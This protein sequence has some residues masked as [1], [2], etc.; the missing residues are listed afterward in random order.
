[1]SNSAKVEANAKYAKLYKIIENADGEN[2][3]NNKDDEK[4]DDSSVDSMDE[5]EDEED[6]FDELLWELLCVKCLKYDW[7]IYEC[8]QKHLELYYNIEKDDPYQEIMHDVE[9]EENNGS[10]FVDALDG[11]IRKHEH[12]IENAAFEYRNET[13][14][15]RHEP[16]NVWKYL[17]IPCKYRCNW[18]SI[19]ECKCE[20][21]SCSLL[22]RFRALALTLNAMKID[23]LIQDIV[24]SIEKRMDDISL[25][26]A[27]DRQLKQREDQIVSK[28]KIA[29]ERL[30]K[31]GYDEETL[32][33]MFEN[34]L[35]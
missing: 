15:W 17:A 23:D 22:R 35:Q 20:N 14:Y 31:K 19:S 11:A 26:D 24:E 4:S 16:P 34:K 18:Q 6:L 3:F 25:E 8:M 7:S 32:L 30:E 1:M 21:N 12:L 9:I 13:L 27:I 10:S 2:S 28:F 5:C 29:H 33:K